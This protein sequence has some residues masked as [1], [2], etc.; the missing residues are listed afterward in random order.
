MYRHSRAD[1]DPDPDL[2]LDHTSLA[3]DLASRHLDPGTEMEVLSA[4]LALLNWAPCLSS[5]THPPL[6][7]PP[8]T[9]PLPMIARAVVLALV[10]DLLPDVRRRL[11]E[12]PATLHPG[13]QHR[14]S[15]CLDSP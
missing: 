13:P 15:P 9:R 2:E 11:M 7:S 3:E 5:P 14:Q 6:N 8:H 12:S 4:Q 1:P 10:K